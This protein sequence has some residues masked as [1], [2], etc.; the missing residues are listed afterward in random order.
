MEF[1]KAQNLTWQEKLKKL[2]ELCSLEKLETISQKLAQISQII[3]SKSELSESE[4]KEIV[5]HLN[6]WSL[7]LISNITKENIT[8]IINNLNETLGAVQILQV[9]NKLG[10]KYEK[11]HYGAAY[12]EITTNPWELKGIK[13]K[14]MLLNSLNNFTD[15]PYVKKYILKSSPTSFKILN[16]NQKMGGESMRSSTSTDNMG[17]LVWTVDKGAVFISLIENPENPRIIEFSELLTT[18]EL[19]TMKMEIDNDK[20]GI[21]VTCS[22]SGNSQ[23]YPF[24][25]PIIPRNQVRK[26]VIAFRDFDKISKL[27]VVVN[28]SGEYKVIYPEIK[29]ASN[30]DLVWNCQVFPDNS[31]Q[32]GKKKFPYL[33]WDGRAEATREINFDCGFCVAKSEVIKF[34]EN[35]CCNFGFDSSLTTDFVTFWS[36]FLRENEFSLIKV[37]SE[38]ECSKIATL[39]IKSNKKIDE[40]QIIRMYIAFQKVPKKVKIKKQILPKIPLSNL[41]KVFDWGGFEL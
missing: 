26:P 12:Y 31:I 38:L 16:R 24:G 21:T 4:N 6:S 35:I 34:L 23:F 17:N 11:F 13:A 40:F 29:V 2:I 39:E 28:F 32:I 1:E 15:Q 33:F 10:F 22:K 36:P 5:K 14:E 3:L 9:E 30:N 27:K 8:E 20:K 41:P 25:T 7:A 18:G 37:L 19:E